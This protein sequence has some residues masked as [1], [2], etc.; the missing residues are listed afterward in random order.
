[1]LALGQFRVQTATK[2]FN[3]FH[4]TLWYWEIPCSVGTAQF[5]VHKQD[6]ISKFQVNVTSSPSRKVF[7]C[8]LPLDGVLSRPQTP[9]KP[10]NRRNILFTL[11]TLTRIK[12]VLFFFLFI[13][14]NEKKCRNTFTN[15]NVI[16]PGTIVTLGRESTNPLI[17]SRTVKPYGASMP[18]I[19]TNSPTMRR[20]S[21]FITWCYG[22]QY[23]ID[24]CQRLR[25]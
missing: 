12:V 4:F 22:Y 23:E 3:I 14:A 19:S 1:M 21:W 5:G 11:S 9:A 15:W 10:S 20:I 13:R 25:F 7:P 17:S 18:E 6:M 16:A 2:M 24:Q 8:N